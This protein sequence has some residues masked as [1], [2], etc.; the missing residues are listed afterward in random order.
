MCDFGFAVWCGGRKL[1]SVCGSPQ[2]MAPELSNKREP[3]LGY[4]VDVWA[5]CAVVYEM[6]HGKPAFRGSSMEQLGIRIMRV[7]H[8]GF[9]PEA[10]P[11]ARSFIKR[12]FVL[13]PIKRCSMSE[14]SAHAW[15]GIFAKAT[16]SAEAASV[17]EMT[18][19]V[20]EVLPITDELE[21]E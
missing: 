21:I 18:Q 10:S 9:G 7:S 4:P 2:Y 17:A 11:A 19:E 20:A 6:L 3:Y 12:G 5:L 16:P 8:E 14:L 15:L 13:D 1:S